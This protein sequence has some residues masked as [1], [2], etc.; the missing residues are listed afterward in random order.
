M[1][2][3][4]R[5]RETETERDKLLYPFW[6]MLIFCLILC[7]GFKLSN[8]Q[9]TNDV[10]DFHVE[11]VVSCVHLRSSSQ[12]PMPSS[13]DCSFFSASS[14]TSLKMIFVFCGFSKCFFCVC[15]FGGFKTVKIHRSV[16]I[17]FITIAIAITTT[18]LV[19]HFIHLT[20]GLSCQ[21]RKQ[22]HICNKGGYDK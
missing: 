9:P 8:V 7:G 18:L 13:I 11:V 20:H 17:L 21:R 3:P 12:Y 16:D 22:M 15:V 5:D 2:G 1:K 19:Q 14:H 10:D 4:E 6:I